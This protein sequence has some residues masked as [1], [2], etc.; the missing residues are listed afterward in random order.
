MALDMQHGSFPHLRYIEH[1]KN[2]RTLLFL[3]PCFLQPNLSYVHPTL[4]NARLAQHPQPN[5]LMQVHNVRAARAKTG[6]RDC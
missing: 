6:T 1:V 2:L 3:P 5:E 4:H